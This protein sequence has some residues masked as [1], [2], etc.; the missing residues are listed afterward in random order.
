LF[1]ERVRRYI[2]E[3]LL[4]L[5]WRAHRAAEQRR[6]RS[7]PPLIVDETAG[8]PERR[9][10]TLAIIC[11]PHFNQSVPNAITKHRRGLATG[12][13]QAGLSCRYVSF[14]ELHKLRELENPIVFIQ[15]LDYEFL[16]RRQIELLR[17]HKLFVWVDPW[18]EDIEAFIGPYDFVGTSLSDR[19]KENVLRS[20]PAFVFTIAPE[21]GLEYYD[22][23]RRRGA[24]LISLPL[25]CDTGL[26]WQS[27]GTGKYDAVR[28]AFVGGYWP[29]KARS[30]D[31][32]LKP[33]ESMLTV[34]GYWPW[35]Y[36][37]YGGQLSDEEEP[38]LYR[39]AALSPAINEPHVSVMGIDLNERVF[40]VLGSGGLCVTDV[41]PAYA[42][43]FA[44]GELLIPQTLDEYHDMVRAVLKDPAAFA[45]YRE[46]GRAAVQQRH[47]YKHR[48]EQVLSLLH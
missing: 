13:Q 9:E 35:P 30:F 27:N 20:E 36:A 34:Y 3:R 1:R 19:T 45:R 22:G 43:L 14:L 2:P 26:Y 10:R 41:T 28:I 31:L 15:E 21:P 16:G 12:F 4:R 29:Y 46:A 24:A 18:R 23:W 11:G 37:G 7:R 32:Y 47:T 38:L 6:I 42:S 25:A 39:N 33:Y 5:K 8:Q 17:R 40:K 44:P 48:A